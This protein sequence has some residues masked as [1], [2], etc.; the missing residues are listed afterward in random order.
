MPD[1]GPQIGG[2]R[3]WCKGQLDVLR[4]PQSRCGGA[5][6]WHAAEQLKRAADAAL[7]S[8][9]KAGAEWFEAKRHILRHGPNGVNKVIY[10]LRYLS[11]KGRG[12]A[13]IRKTFGYFFNNRSRMNYYHLAKDG[14]PIG[15]GEVEAANKVLVTQC[16]KRFGQRWSRDGGQGVLSYRALLKSDRFSRAREMIVPRIER[17]KRHWASR[18]QLLQMI[19][20]SPALL[21]D[22]LM[23]SNLA[24]ACDGEIVQ[25]RKRTPHKCPGSLLEILYS[26][27]QPRN[28]A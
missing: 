4:K 18:L 20:G 12:R 14:Y 25:H 3:G 7:G 1:S 28:K 10:A 6:F 16:L 8:D 15:S 26:T 2:L 21:R 22:A 19:T 27:K 5:R 23:A 24:K 11:R 9:E 13:E 17:L